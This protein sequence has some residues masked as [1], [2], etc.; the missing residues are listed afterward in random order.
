[1][2]TCTQLQ[3]GYQLIWEYFGKVPIS[4]K[5]DPSI[6]SL[7][8]EILHDNRSLGSLEGR[9]TEQAREIS[10][11]IERLQLQINQKVYSLYDLTTEEISIVDAAT[12]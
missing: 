12:S 11:R 7:V 1:M 10:D 5:I 6:E 2:N 8:D 4:Q 3:G 9:D